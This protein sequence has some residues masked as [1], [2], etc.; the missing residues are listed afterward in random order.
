MNRRLSDIIKNI[1]PISVQKP[2]I[3]FVTE[4]SAGYDA[5]P[6]I[7]GYEKFADKEIRELNH[8]GIVCYVSSVLAPHVF[9]VSF[10]EIY[11]SFR[12]NFIPTLVFIG[13]YIQPESSKYFNPDMFGEL[14]A[15][16]VSLQEKKLTPIMGGDL[17]CR[18]G[19]FNQL[20]EDAG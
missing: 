4:T 3:I 20:R 8:G 7:R 12:L 16:L 6:F 15:F 10:N 18:F 13:C 11:V 9:N 5:I 2:D 17:N 14:G 19:N 1:S